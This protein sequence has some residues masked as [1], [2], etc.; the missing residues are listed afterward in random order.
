MADGGIFFTQ[1][2]WNIVSE[3]LQLEAASVHKIEVYRLMKDN[4]ET[5]R[6]DPALYK[7]EAEQMLAY[8]PEAKI[9]FDENMVYGKREKKVLLD[10]LPDAPMTGYCLRLH[11]FS[12]F[13]FINELRSVQRIKAVHILVQKVDMLYKN[14]SG[15]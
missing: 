15:Q 13:G 2:G 11:D 8:L 6:F 10:A 4:T 3:G 12:R 9:R 1:E 7:V 5:L 14:I